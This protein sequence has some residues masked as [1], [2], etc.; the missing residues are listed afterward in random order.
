MVIIK[1]VTELKAYDVKQT[2]GIEAEGVTIRWISER[3]TGGP[4]YLHN[5]ALRHFTL[6][7]GGYIAPHRHA[8][9]QEVAVT[10]GKLLI[11]GRGQGRIIKEED[12]AYFSAD[13]EHGFKVLGD[14]PSEFYCIIG[15]IGK[16]ENCIGLPE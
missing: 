11:T 14:K 9:E 7:A 8:W 5:F 2:Y 3:G 15:C 13:E 1:N 10:K 4:D 16:G 6:E 12:V